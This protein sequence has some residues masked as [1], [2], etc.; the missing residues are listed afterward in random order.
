MEYL[1]VLCVPRVLA[2]DRLDEV[3]DVEP[4]LPSLGV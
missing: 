3:K 1:E 4:L 2:F